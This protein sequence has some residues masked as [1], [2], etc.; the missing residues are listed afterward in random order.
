MIPPNFRKLPVSKR[1]KII[2]EYFKLDQEELNTL[3]NQIDLSDL[4]DVFVE[5]SIGTFPIPFGLATGFLID[6]QI[7]LMPMATEEPSVIAAS[8][9]A[10]RLVRAGSGFKTWSD[11]PIMTTQIYLKDSHHDAVEK[12]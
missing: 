12:I 2:K 11:D 4:A 9:Y 3:S 1:R 7:K 5:S 6:R 10:A 8:N